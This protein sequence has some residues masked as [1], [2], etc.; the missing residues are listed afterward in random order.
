MAVLSTLGRILC[1]PTFICAQ[2]HFKNLLP[3]SMDQCSLKFCSRLPRLKV[4]SHF[5]ISSYQRPIPC[6]GYSS[7]TA[8]TE[9]SVTSQQGDVLRPYVTWVT[10]VPAAS[11]VSWLLG[12]V[13][14]FMTLIW[15]TLDSEV[16]WHTEWEV[17][18]MARRPSSVHHVR[19]WFFTSTMADYSLS[20]A[21]IN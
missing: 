15:I 20:T 2:P 7:V 17:F 12:L 21:C 19:L 3:W 6:C 8:S 11:T 5:T 13:L 9:D 10:L 18:A 16:P 4:N 14:F 1:L